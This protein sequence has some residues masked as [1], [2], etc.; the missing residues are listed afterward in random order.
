MTA[1][2]EQPSRASLSTRVRRLKRAAAVAR[3]EAGAALTGAS[4]PRAASAGAVTGLLGRA[5]STGLRI[6]AGVVRRHP[7]SATL[8]AGVL[9]GTALYH[10]SG[11]AE[12]LDR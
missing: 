4:H 3:D 12:D 10:W 11:R 8:I 9:V 1:L 7:V 2:H 6:A 5:G